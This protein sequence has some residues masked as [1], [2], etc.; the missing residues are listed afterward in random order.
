MYDE[1]ENEQGAIADFMSEISEEAWCA[2]WMSGLEYALWDALINGP[3]EYGWLKL[4]VRI[5]EKLKELSA[6]CGGWIIFDDSKEEVFVPL[7]ER[8]KL[9]HLKSAEI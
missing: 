7:D 8:Q 3:Q 5:I 9:Y 6:N 1:L 2:G 4:S